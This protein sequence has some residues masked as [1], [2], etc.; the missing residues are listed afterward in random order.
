MTLVHQ[1]TSSSGAVGTAAAPLPSRLLHP[2]ARRRVLRQEQAQ[3]QRNQQLAWRVQDTLGALG[4]FQKGSSI[5]GGPSF[6]V[7]VVTRVDLGPPIRLTI[8]TLPGQVPE[9]FT[10]HTATIAH[11][12][13]MARVRV[14][15]GGASLLYLELFA[16]DP[17]AG[18]VPL[19]RK[20]LANVRDLVLLG[21]D[22]G[23]LRYQ[24]SPFDLVHLAIQGSTGSGKSV[25]V[26][27]LL[28]QLVAT[29]DLLIAISDP[30]GLLTRPFDG[31]IHQPWQ[32]S[33]TSDPD[34][35]LHLLERLVEE[36]DR[37]IATLPL[38][39]D[40][41]D[42]GPA[43]PLIFLF[44]EEYAGLLIAAAAG[45]GA[46]KGGR[47]DQIKHLVLRL[48][49]EGR[50]A[51]I[52]LVILAQRFEA[53]VVSGFARS[54]CTVKI[55]FRVDNADSVAMLHPTGRAEADE[56]ATCAPGVALLTGPGVPL[57]RIR[58]PFIGA[59]DGDTA[60]GRYWDLITAVARRAPSSPA[61][62]PNA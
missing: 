58:S 55:T 43:C 54:Q 20:P 3:H 49:T 62:A 32:I 22:D 4:L 14:I 6:R 5:A 11:N 12:L 56:H 15:N 41:V 34:E 53:A 61:Q 40:Q 31:T 13:G 10:P 46:K 51:G 33:G 24:I 8:V 38:R 42:L 1:T 37:R 30:T 52:R 7:P 36:M 29:P 45:D 23:S 2:L 26:Y 39:R 19:P 44:L 59:D 35:H 9:D 57:A 25:F 18:D 21:V 48:I 16:A 47:V 50:K 60:Y 28:A 27:G 17:L